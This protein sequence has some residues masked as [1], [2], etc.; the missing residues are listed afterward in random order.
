MPWP[1]GYF[2]LNPFARKA[3]VECTVITRAEKA[4]GAE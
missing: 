3:G 2:E 1:E 4:M